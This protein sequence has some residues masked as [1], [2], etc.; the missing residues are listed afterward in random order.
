MSVKQHAFY[1]K[2]AIDE[3]NLKDALKHSAAMLSELRTSQLSPQMYYALYM[4]A[5]D[6]MRYLETY[7]SDLSRSG[8]SVA[9]LYELVQHAGNILP[10]MYLLVTVASVF[11]STKEAA[12]KDVLKDVVEMT[13]GVQHPLRGLFLRA[14]LAQMSKDKLPDLGSMYEGEGGSVE[15]AVEFILQ[16][17]TEMNKLWVRMQHQGPVRLKERRE[18]DRNELRD[19]VGKNLLVLSQLEGVDLALYQDTVLPWVLEQVVNC[20]DVIAQ[21]YLMDAIIQVFP[22]DFHLHTLE[23]LDKACAQLQPEVAVGGILVAL[24][25]RLARYASE[26]PEVLPMMEREGVFER[27]SDAVSQATSL[28]APA[29]TAEVVQLYHELMKFVA[30]IDSASLDRLDRVLEACAA[31]LA[32]RRS[33]ITG[34]AARELTALLSSPLE[35]FGVVATLSLSSYPGLVAL[36]E[37]GA[38]RH[39]GSTIIRT[40]LKTGAVVTDQ[41]KV[42]MLLENISRLVKD[43]EGAEPPEVDEDFEEEQQL[44]ARLVATAIQGSTPEVQLK[45]LHTVRKHFGAGGVARLRF[46]LPP[47]VFLCLKLARETVEA[48]A[49][50]QVSLKKV[51]QFLHQTVQVLADNG[52]VPDIALRLYLHC[53]MAADAAQLEPIACEFFTQALVVYEEEVSDSRAQVSAMNLIIGALRSCRCITQENRDSLVHKCAGYSS[54]LLKKADQC[55]AAY[56]CS[57]LFWTED[58][59]DSENVLLCLKRSL[60]IANKAQEMASAAHAESVSSTLFVEVLNKYLYFFSDGNE[61]VTPSILQGLMELIRNEMSENGAGPAVESFY[62][63]TLRHIQHQK[64]QGGEVGERYAALAV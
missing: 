52:G 63:S 4:N 27:L 10:R 43:P 39:M 51:F 28:E 25:E 21:T 22:D 40:I 53:A 34:K 55:R 58:V 46:T 48:G 2:R 13:R 33:S 59:K 38:R 26:S 57:H 19:L 32:P 29:S 18:K 16:N 14:Y 5:C 30:Q 9:E 47:L 42:E 54:R 49:A 12:A 23:A 61:A 60:K 1:M 6:E 45:M 44:V 56:V 37:D 8:R 64:A 31:A 36:L 62:R 41:P 7:F 50:A 17:F 24:M 11:I 35:A 3:G 15:D 20:K